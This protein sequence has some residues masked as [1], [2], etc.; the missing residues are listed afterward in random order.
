MENRIYS[1]N[2]PVVTVKDTSDFSMMEMVYVGNKRLLGEVI[3][4]S[5]GK[6]TIQ[7]YESTTGLKPGE[8]VEGSGTLL[9]VTLGPG[10]LKNI[11][12]GIERP[13]KDLLEHDGAFI[14]EGQTVSALDDTRKWDVEMLVKKGDKVIGGQIFAT[15]VET[16]LITHRSM[17]P[18]F[19]SGEVVEAK[20]NGSYTAYET[21]LCVV[22]ENGERHEVS[23]SQKWPIKKPRPIK[24]RKPIGIPLITGQRVIDTT[25]PIAKGGAAAVPGGFGAGKT[26][27]QHQI[28]KWCDA[29]IIVYVGCGER[30]NEMT[31]VLEEFSELIDPR[32]G[33]PLL[34]RTVLIANTSNMPVAAREASIYTGITLAEY[35]RDMGYHVAIMA[36][37]TSRWA[38]ALRE[39]S[40]R[41]EEMPA[42]EGFPAYLPSRIAQF[43]ERICR[44]YQ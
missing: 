14:S 27:L 19:V 18:P 43:Y 25:F 31:Q 29:D 10:I 24:N 39:I 42:E 8:I 38:E 34:D 11:F 17:I 13:L 22:D 1:I 37:S 33:K 2:G 23:L 20:G 35:Y 9:S 44:E 41:L 21:L 7:V 30:G 5:K 40:G 28:A 32:T 6:T 3:G 26:M 15:C 16:P 4:I 36:D 12:D